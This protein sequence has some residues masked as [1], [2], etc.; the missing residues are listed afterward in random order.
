V[1]VSSPKIPHSS[2]TLYKSLARDMTVFE[3]FS[4]TLLELLVQSIEVPRFLRREIS[5]LHC[6]ELILA[7]LEIVAVFHRP[8]TRVG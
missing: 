1:T 6:S 8:W 7:R 5:P 2:Q 4:A 3:H